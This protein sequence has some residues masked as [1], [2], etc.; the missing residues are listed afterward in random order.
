MESKWKTGWH[1]EKSYHPQCPSLSCAYLGEPGLAITKIKH[2]IYTPANQQQQTY[3]FAF[4][5]GTLLDSALWQAWGMYSGEPCWVITNMSQERA[6][7]S[8]VPYR[9]LRDRVGWSPHHL[10]HPLLQ[11]F[12]VCSEPAQGR[13]GN[14]PEH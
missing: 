1:R 14:S 12:I 10:T 11:P 6:A 3:G 4:S 8:L 7:A 5:M 2:Q 9:D 13:A